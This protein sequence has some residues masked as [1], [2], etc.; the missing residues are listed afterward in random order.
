MIT[1]PDDPRLKTRLIPFAR[2]VRRTVRSGGGVPRGSTLL[3]GVFWSPAG[4]YVTYERSRDFDL[5]GVDEAGL[6][7]IAELV[8]KEFGQES[9]LTFRHLP[10]TSP[11][12]DAVRVEVPGIDVRRLDQGLATDQV[13]RDRLGGGSVTLGHR[14][15]LVAGVADLSLVHR[16]VTT[17]GGD[18]KAAG[19]E[20]G[21][22]EFVS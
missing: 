7:H 1:D 8:R 11:S 15:V 2:E 22:W 10:R 14:L 17:L 12:V 19:V 18:W 3:D 9:V 21:D 5:D 16:F 6:R 13:V 4:R 20:Y